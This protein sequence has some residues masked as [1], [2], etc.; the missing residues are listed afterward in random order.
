MM[1]AILGMIIAIAILSALAYYQMLN[2]YNLE[3]DEREA[4]W[5]AETEKPARKIIASDPGDEHSGSEITHR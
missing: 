2:D 4:D 5:Y 1:Y 3:I